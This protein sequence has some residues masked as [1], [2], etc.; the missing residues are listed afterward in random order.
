MKKLILL[1]L[2]IGSVIMFG[3]CSLFETDNY[4]GPDTT[5]QGSITDMDGNSLNVES[6]NGIRIKI[7]GLWLERKS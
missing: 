5:L 1:T 4:D 2:V 7:D 6:G 3:S